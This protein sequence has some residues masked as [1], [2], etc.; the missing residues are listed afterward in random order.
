M[1]ENTEIQYSLTLNTEMAYSDTRKLETTIVRALGELA[2]L[3]NNK[4]IKAFTTEIIEAIN[5][6]R[7]AQM[8]AKALAAIMM[9]AEAGELLTPAGGIKL[10]YAAVGAIAIGISASQFMMNPGS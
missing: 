5:L 7:Q 1:S 9:L 10:A 8:E 3:T 4:D 2:T 6:L